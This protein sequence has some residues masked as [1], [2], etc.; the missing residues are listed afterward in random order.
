MIK[1][2]Q[3]EPV[4]KLVVQVLVPQALAWAIQRQYSG[5][6]FGRDQHI[7]KYGNSNEPEHCWVAVQYAPAKRCQNRALNSACSRLPGEPVNNL[8]D[9]L[10]GYI[11]LNKV[12]HYK[13]KGYSC[14]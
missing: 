11:K 14:Q 2:W 9:G 10:K 7:E 8:A 13:K 3:K 6:N 12:F 5:H 1:I 4:Q